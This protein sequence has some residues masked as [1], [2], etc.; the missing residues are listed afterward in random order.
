[1][2]NVRLQNVSRLYRHVRALDDVT[3]EV[4][5]KSLTVLCGPPAAGKSVLLRLLVGLEQPDSG[6]H[7]HQ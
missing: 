6:P 3:I 7:P 4:A 1:M 5:S 2:S